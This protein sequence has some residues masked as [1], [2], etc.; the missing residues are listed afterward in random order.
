MSLIQ[1]LRWI[2]LLRLVQPVSA[3][4]AVNTSTRP[5][6]SASFLVTLMLPNQ[7]FINVLLTVKG[8]TWSGR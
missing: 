8:Q 2:R 5:K 6:P 7:P 1:L 3:N 4:S